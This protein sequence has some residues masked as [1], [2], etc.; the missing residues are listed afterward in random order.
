MNIAIFFLALT[1]LI[2]GTIGIFI[3]PAYQILNFGNTPYTYIELD[4]KANIPNG[5][6]KYGSKII[7]YEKEI[8]NFYDKNRENQQIK[9]SQNCFKFIDKNGSIDDI[10]KFSNECKYTF[11]KEYNDFVRIY[12]AIALSTLGKS[13]NIKAS[14]DTKFEINKKFIRGE[15]KA[16]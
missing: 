13:Y 15:V 8:L 5:I 14:N 7:S 12:N 11:T 9:I 16:D 2:I 6:Y 3:K 1:I 10:D 4:K